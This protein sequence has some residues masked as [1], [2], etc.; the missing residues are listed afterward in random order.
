MKPAPYFAALAFSELIAFEQPQV[1]STDPF[2]VQMLLQPT[3][4]DVLVI[5]S[6]FE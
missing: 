4:E 5:L 2:G 1:E 6:S 3:L